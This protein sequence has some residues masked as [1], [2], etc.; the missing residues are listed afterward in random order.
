[1]KG[2]L[3][4]I[5]QRKAECKNDD[6]TVRNYIPP[7]FYERFTA[8]NKIC[9][10]RRTEDPTL[11]TQ[12]RFGQRDLIVLTKEKGTSDPFREVDFQDFV[13]HKRL[14]GFDMSVKWR[15]MEDRPPR[16][17]I[18]SNKPASQ[19]E[20]SS[21]PALQNQTSRQLST[22]SQEENSRKKLRRN[23]QE[24]QR[25]GVPAKEQNEMEDVDMN[26]TQ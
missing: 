25:P 15:I 20:L 21:Q 2:T 11:K 26:V 24:R 14:P 12:I 13:G 5:Y 1:M 10:L 22:G 9:G 3:R 7:H 6:T 19:Q 18:A 4:D 8:L 16:R 23:S 17:R